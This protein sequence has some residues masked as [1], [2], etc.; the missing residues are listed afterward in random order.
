[1]IDFLN[2]IKF[3]EGVIIIIGEF[4]FWFLESSY[5]V[6]YVSFVVLVKLL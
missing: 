4:S 6:E 3:L 5:W 1:M 2:M